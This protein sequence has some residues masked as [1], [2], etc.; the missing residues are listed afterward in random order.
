MKP[1]SIWRLKFLGPGEWRIKNALLQNEEY[2]GMLHSA[3]SDYMRSSKMIYAVEK[4]EG[5]KE[6]CKQTLIYAERMEISR[7]KKEGTLEEWERRQQLVESRIPPQAT[8]DEANSVLV[9]VQQVRSNKIIKE[10]R[11]ENGESLGSN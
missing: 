2:I 10:L 4:W 1:S 9:R 7:R 11:K 6:V 8:T 3:I 5:L